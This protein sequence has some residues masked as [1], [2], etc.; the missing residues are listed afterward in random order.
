[1]KGIP[2]AHPLFSAYWRK[3]E[4]PPAEMN[5][6]RD[7]CGLIWCSPI[8]PNTGAHAARITSLVKERMLSQGFE[9]IVSLTVLTERTLSC[10]VS[11]TYDRSLKD[12][13]SKAAACYSHLLEPWLKMDITLTALE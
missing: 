9:P 3:R 7:G 4:A 8:A 11:I 10:I 5:P 2:T 6:D 12:E 13:D 1:M